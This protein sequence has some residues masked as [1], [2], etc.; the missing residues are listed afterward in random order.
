MSVKLAC[1]F[2][3]W[4]AQVI[5]QP[6]IFCCSCRAR[7][8]TFASPFP[9]TTDENRASIN[10]QWTTRCEQNC[11]AHWGGPLWV[12]SSSNG[13]RFL[14]VALRWR[15]HG[16]YPRELTGV[17]CREAACVLSGKRLWPY[18]QLGK[19]SSLRDT[20]MQKVFSGVLEVPWLFGEHYFQSSEWALHS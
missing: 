15:T 14:Q 9:C 17:P 19:C 5:T 13:N 20:P 2:P 12:F 7:E 16:W 18:C 1:I 10:I 8:Q 3:E 11:C 6:H 4:M